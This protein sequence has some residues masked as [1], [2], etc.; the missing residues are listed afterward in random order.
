MYLNATTW[1]NLKLFLIFCN[2][3]LLKEAIS[4]SKLSQTVV[5]LKM[6]SSAAR[7]RHVRLKHQ[8]LGDP[9]ASQIQIR[10]NARQYLLSAHVTVKMKMTAAS[11]SPVKGNHQ[12]PHMLSVCLTNPRDQST[13]NSLSTL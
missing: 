2:L 12:L 7:S 3:S 9:S 8:A 5:V 11:T 4:A 1:P 10:K 6:K 13:K